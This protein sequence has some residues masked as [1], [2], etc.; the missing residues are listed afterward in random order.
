MFQ[1]AWV[2]VNKP[3]DHL[4]CSLH[5]SAEVHTKLWAA[6]AETAHPHP[7]ICRA[8]NPFQIILTKT[9]RR[10]L[11]ALVDIQTCLLCASCSM[12]PVSCFLGYSHFYY[13]TTFTAMN[14]QLICSQGTEKQRKR[15]Q[16]EQEQQP[17][18]LESDRCKLELP[19]FK[20]DA[21]AQTGH[22]HMSF[23]SHFVSDHLILATLCRFS[24]A[25]IECGNLLL[26]WPE[27][28]VRKWCRS[29]SSSSTARRLGGR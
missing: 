14:H 27:F 25:A 16:I 13:V 20:L 15:T 29:S 6:N 28:R 5:C 4:L 26:R 23:T 9:Y 7:A 10:L 12:R 24:L 19:N 22:M 11:E 18:A 3:R 1:P 17:T 2:P 21:K 8:F